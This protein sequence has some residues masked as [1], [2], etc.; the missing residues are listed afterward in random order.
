MD[1]FLDFADYRDFIKDFAEKRKQRIPSFSYR[2]MAKILGVD[3]SHLHRVLQKRQHLP[4]RGFLALKELLNLTPRQAQIFELMYEAANT[5]NV[6][7][8]NRLLSKA[9]ALQDLV[10]RRIQRSEVRVLNHWWTPVVFSALEVTHGVY[11]A[12]CLKRLIVPEVSLDDIRESLDALLYFGFIKK[13]SSGRCVHVDAHVTAS[14]E[15]EPSKEY[16]QEYQRNALELAKRA[17]LDFPAEDRDVSTIAFAVD[18]E[19]FLEIKKMATEFRMLVQKRVDKVKFPDRVMQLA[20]AL[21]PV[22]KKG[23]E[24]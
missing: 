6:N 9:F 8:K 11:D 4:Y 12:H 7:E 16:V 22:T 1:Q 18:E 19:C 2:Q 10:Q 14:R 21:F 20:L 23:N 15:V 5:C 3:A 24:E 17:I 13:L